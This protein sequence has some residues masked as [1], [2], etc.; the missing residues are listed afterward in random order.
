MMGPTNSMWE[1]NK[2]NYEQLVNYTMLYDTGDECVDVTGGWVARSIDTTYPNVGTLTKNSDRLSYTVSGSQASGP[3]TVDM[4]DTTGYKN[5]YVKQT[6]K[7]NSASYLTLTLDDKSKLV[8]NNIGTNVNVT[9]PTF[10][11]L[12]VSEVTQK[13][14]FTT[15]ISYTGYITLYYAFLVKEDDW[16]TLAD[17]VGITATSIDDI[18][19]NSITLLNNEDAVEFMIKQCTGDFM[20]QAIQSETFLTE[21]NNS[22]YKTKI[23]AN[24]HW[25]KFLNMLA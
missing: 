3:G 24:E 5:I 22:V 13:G 4:I 19:T 11:K 6:F 16:Q 10:Y 25:R 12:D 14:Y 18:L 15:S 8:R 23:Q 21:L 9:T 2:S 20:A 7:A 17:K 1:I